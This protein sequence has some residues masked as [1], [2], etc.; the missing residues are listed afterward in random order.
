MG[1]ISTLYKNFTISTVKNKS[2]KLKSYLLCHELKRTTNLLT[3]TSNT[4]NSC[5]LP[6][7]KLFIQKIFVFCLSNCIGSKNMKWILIHKKHNMYPAKRHIFLF[8]SCLQRYTSISVTQQRPSICSFSN[9]LPI[10]LRNIEHIPAASEAKI[11]KV[12]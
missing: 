3:L 2:C 9:M 1:T 5:Q 10:H 12:F 6:Y 8:L 11:N 4:S 7:G